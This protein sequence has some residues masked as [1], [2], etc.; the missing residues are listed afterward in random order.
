MNPWKG[1]QTGITRKT[2]DGKPEGGFVA[3]EAISLEDGI[4]AYTLGA[5]FAGR[6]E[7][8]E[9]SLQAGKLADMI[10]VDQDLFKI[11]AS[12]IGKTQ[13]LLT[14]VGGKTVYESDGWRAKNGS[15]V[16]EAK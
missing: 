9:G 15:K 16:S 2:E 14:M 10:I 11:P 6:K 1:L 5:A 3:S 8:E 12:E 4:K 13:V 7:K